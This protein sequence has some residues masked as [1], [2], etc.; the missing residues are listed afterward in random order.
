M[1]NYKMN[2]KQDKKNQIYRLI[3]KTHKNKMKVKIMIT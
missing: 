2:K 3:N 1:N